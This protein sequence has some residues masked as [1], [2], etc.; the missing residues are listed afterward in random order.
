MKK[1]ASKKFLKALGRRI[2]ELRERQEISQSQ[3]AFEC[4]IPRTQVSRIELGTHSTSVSNILAIANSLNIRLKE[5]YDF[6][7]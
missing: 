1:T 6:E 4:D 5:L 7:Y 3:L 2:K